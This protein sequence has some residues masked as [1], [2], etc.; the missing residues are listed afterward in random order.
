[1]LQCSVMIMT[2]PSTE[3]QILEEII[4]KLRPLDVYKQVSTIF[5][6]PKDK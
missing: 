3:R 1:M 2:R 4:P 5:T 6:F